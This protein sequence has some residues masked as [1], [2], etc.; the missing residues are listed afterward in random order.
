MFGRPKY[1]G[2]CHAA[3]TRRGLQRQIRRSAEH[4]VCIQ[5]LKLRFIVKGDYSDD[6]W[7]VAHPRGGSLLEFS[8]RPIGARRVS[9]VSARRAARLLVH[10]ACRCEVSLRGLLRSPPAA[11][12]WPTFCDQRA[13]E[14]PRPPSP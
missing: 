11:R 9:A 1:P 8:L 12:R 10:L 14:S 6:T 4:H 7:V 2:V 13:A 3:R 5:E